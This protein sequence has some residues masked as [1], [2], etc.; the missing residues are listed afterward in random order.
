MPSE[1]LLRSPNFT[2]LKAHDPQLVMLGVLAERYFADDPNTCLI[3]LRQFGEVLAQMTAAHIGLYTSPNEKQV[4][5]LRRLRDRGMLKGDV[6]RLFHELRKMGNEATHSL[7]GSQRVALSGLKYARF[8][9]VWFH[10]V[11]SG[12]R[13]F[14]PGPFIPPPDPQ[15]ET[16][17]L[18]DELERLRQEVQK[19]LSAIEIA[20]AQA[21]AEAQKRIAAE[22]LAAEAEAQKQEFIQH[23]EKLQ[24]ASQAQSN[25]S[26]QQTVTQAQIVEGDL[27]LDER[28]TRRLIDA[29]LQE[30]GWEADS[31]ELIYSKGTRPQKGRNL[32]IAE[33]PMARGR[34]VSQKLIKDKRSVSFA[35]P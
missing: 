27:V 14:D 15:Q 34:V 19:S 6:D 23:L 10:K 7:A 16:Q 9:G 3:K 18:K 20:Q 28:E 35:F 26:I 29:Q 30:A 17:S 1:G 22:E 33:F 12:D 32:A 31:E 8:L 21:Q 13:S 24:V 5:L 2:F 25:Q 11:V 4:D